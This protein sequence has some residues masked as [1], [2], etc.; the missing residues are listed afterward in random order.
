[1]LICRYS[2]TGATG[3]DREEG[4]AFLADEVGGFGR[5]SRRPTTGR[6]CSTP[7][8]LSGRRKRRDIFWLGVSPQRASPGCPLC[9][10]GNSG[11][12]RPFSP[13]ASWAAPD[14]F[15][16]AARDRGARRRFLAARRTSRSR[17]PGSTFTR[18]RPCRSASSPA[19]SIS[20][21]VR[22]RRPNSGR[23]SSSGTSPAQ[24]RAWYSAGPACRYWRRSWCREPWKQATEGLRPQFPRRLGAFRCNQRCR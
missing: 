23:Q 7:A 11:P 18:Q 17:S 4:R 8:L 20:S 24:R 9:P 12:R 3:P 22:Q 2:G 10:L 13:R 5:G 14:A 19:A 21:G 15:D 1:M 16:A 6:S